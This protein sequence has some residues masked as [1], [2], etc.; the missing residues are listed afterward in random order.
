VKKSSSRKNAGDPAS[1]L[2][3]YFAS[4][5]PDARRILRK[6]RET[7]R[8]AAPQAVESFSYQMPLFRLEGRPLV[9]YAAFKNHYSL[10]P[11]TDAIKRTLASDLKG[12][13]TS[14][15]TIRFSFSKPVPVTL[16]KRLVKARIAA[17]RKTAKS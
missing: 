7:I 3:E 10:F 15:G 12:Y 11:M 14:K 2:R 5:S 4:Q 6:V 13:E 8:S 16:V 9:W 17:V 1:Q